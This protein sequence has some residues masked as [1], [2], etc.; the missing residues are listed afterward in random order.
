MKNIMIAFALISLGAMIGVIFMCLFQIN[1]GADELDYLREQQ[2][3]ERI[4]DEG[5][6][7]TQNIY[8]TA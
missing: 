8:Y 1:R 3:R 4:K 6:G 2:M 7:W 5:E